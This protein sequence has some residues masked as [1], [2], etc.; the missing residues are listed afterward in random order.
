MIWKHLMLTARTPLPLLVGA[1]GAAVAIGAAAV[2]LVAV[3]RWLAGMAALAGLVGLVTV[4]MAA[5]G[6][7]NDLRSDLLRLDLIRP[8]PIGGKRLFLA[9]VIPPAV[10]LCLHAAA[11]GGL[12][13]VA[14]LAAGAPASA[15]TLGAPYPVVLLIGLATLLVIAAPVA[16]LVATLH[17][18]ATL[19]WP[20]WMHLGARPGVGSAARAGQTLLTGVGIT[21]ALGVGLLPGALLAAGGLIAQ[22][23]WFGVPFTVWELP[24]VG[25]VAV[26]PLALVIGA[27]VRAGGVLWDRFDPS[28]ELLSAGPGA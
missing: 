11:G 6:R 16:L 4:P 5:A 8:W 14:G 24:L 23:G 18:L 3:P 19:A 12:L 27:L 22:V 20:S 28:A 26:L 9:Q 17:N 1:G 2:T 15:A 10:A 21:L 13:L 25:A 7:R